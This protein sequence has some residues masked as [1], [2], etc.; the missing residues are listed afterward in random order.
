MSLSEIDSSTFSQIN[1][2][3]QNDV[4][5]LLMPFITS[6]AYLIF[7]PFFIWILYKE[8]KNSLVILGIALTSILIADWFA[9]EL[10][11]YFERLRPCN[12]LDNV[13]LLIGCG[14]SFSFPS[15]HAVNAFAFA[16]PFY[17]MSKGRV[18]AVFFFIALLVGFSRVYVGVHYP[19]DVIAGAL[20]GTLIALVMMQCYRWA[21]VRFKDRPHTTLLILLLSAFS[22]FRLYYILHGP[23]DLSPDEAHYW[24][25]S[26]R[27]DMSYYSKGPMIAYLISLGT[28]IFGDTVLGIRIMAVIFMGAS[29]ITI[30]YLGKKLHDETVGLAS[31]FILNIIPLFATFG[32]IFTIDSPFIFFWILSLFLFWKTIESRIHEMNEAKYGQKEIRPSEVSSSQHITRYAPSVYW[33]LLGLSVGLGLLTKYTMAL[34][35]PCAAL[36]LFLSKEFRKTLLTKGPVLMLF[37]SLLVFSPVIVWNAQHDWVTFRHTLG[38]THL[39]DGL[40]VSPVSLIE[41]VGSQV[42]VITPFLI[43]LMCLSI[44]KVRKGREGAFLF[45]FAAPV[46]GF[47][48]LKSVQGKVQAN[49]A[50]TGYITGIITFAAWYIRG[51]GVMKRYR[52]ILVIGAVIHTCVVT[53][54]AHYPAILNLPAHMDPSARLRG[55]KAL[56][57]EVS[58]YHDQMQRSNSV[59]IFSD[60]YQVSSELAFYVKDNPV[61]YCIN[62]GRRMNQYDLWPGFHDRLHSDAIFVRNGDRRIPDKIANAFSQVEKRVYKAYT[63][64]HGMGK[65]YSIFLCHDFKGLEEKMPVKY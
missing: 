36:Y 10:K 28:S 31:A 33:A 44:W 9:N 26:R 22:L 5:D 1:I 55:W 62:L 8:R 18:R 42:G 37:I 54:L 57:R 35:F 16:T 52:K 20:F 61:T 49:W 63:K 7:L 21:S 25:W 12:A 13:R 38:Q 29:T 4:F 51:F 48:L 43:V 60:K 24:E 41:F 40:N 39:Y 65:E 56:G 34:F 53:A 27:L 47:F 30:F 32:I 15:N 50:M 2:T 3:F 19:S 6:K 58:R 59:F 45:W 17:L 64:G 23:L 11:L 46:I 14:R